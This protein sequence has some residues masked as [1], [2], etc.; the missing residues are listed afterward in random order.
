MLVGPV[1]LVEDRMN[2][3]MVSAS[4]RNDFV[5]ARMEVGV[6]NRHDRT[7]VCIESP[8]S[9]EVLAGVI[10]FFEAQPLQLDVFP[11]EDLEGG[12]EGV[13]PERS[14]LTNSAMRCLI[15][16][17]IEFDARCVHS[18]HGVRPSRAVDEPEKPVQE[19]EWRDK[20][21]GVMVTFH[22]NDV[23]V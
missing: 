7:F 17:T 14:V 5:D 11:T 16:C 8:R 12:F 4:Y 22:G 19:M 18:R 2:T 15:P 9:G 1:K 13:V 23:V 6:R 10:Q 21:D 20:P 3:H